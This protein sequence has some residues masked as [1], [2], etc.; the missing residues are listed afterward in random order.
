VIVACSA[1]VG[2]AVGTTGVIGFVGLLIPHAVRRIWGSDDR[3][4][5]PASAVLGGA[6]LCAFDGAA[7][8]GF[9]VVGSEVPVGAACALMGAPLFAVL[10]WG[11]RDRT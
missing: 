2:V 11:S 6:L 3:L 10:L 7:R 5:I 4:V 1:L 8:L 9:A